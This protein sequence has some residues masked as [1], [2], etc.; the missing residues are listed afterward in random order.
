MNNLQYWQERELEQRD[1]LYDKTLAEYEAEL[2]KQYQQSLKAV[3]RDIEK[4]Y[5]ELLVS[6]A[7]GTLLASDLYKYN[8]YFNLMKSLNKQLKALGGEEITI[9]NQKLLDMY[10]ITSSAVG[11]SIG[12]SGE[13]SQK[14]AKEVINSIWCADGK[15]WSDRIWQNKAQLQVALEKG[16]VDCV[17][18][19]VSKDELVKTL[20]ETFNVGYRKADR[21][22]RT[23]L[24][25]VQNKAA[26]NK[27]EEVGLDEYEILAAH[28]ERTCPI[29][30]KMNG[31]R[32]KLSEAEAG[33]NYPPL[34][35]N[36]RCA[37]LGVIK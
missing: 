1:L 23:E 22:A 12:F 18:R 33:V 16:L 32:F 27:Y 10:A 29:C 7:D 35:S 15:H 3:S 34:H 5:D 24:S 14:T 36:C 26:M 37:V 19:G 25:Y 8:R 30:G 21:I 17:S 20:M 6:S 31:K 11:E 4:L 13:F 2:K 9:T 28:D